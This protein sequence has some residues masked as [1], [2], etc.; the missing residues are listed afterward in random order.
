MLNAGR[1][2]S[3]AIAQAWPQNLYRYPRP[4]VPTVLR[5]TSGLFVMELPRWVAPRSK[6]TDWCRSSR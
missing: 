6:N 3:S 1:V 4:A 5:S 2:D